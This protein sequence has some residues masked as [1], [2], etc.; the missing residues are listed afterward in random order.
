MLPMQ[1][2]ASGGP[3]SEL[4][5]PS[6]QP[7]G[8]PPP[9]SCSATWTD[10]VVQV[11]AWAA[12]SRAPPSCLASPAAPPPAS[13]RSRRP[14][15]ATANLAPP[16]PARYHQ[17]NCSCSC[18]RRLSEDGNASARFPVPFCP[19]VCAMRC[20]GNHHMSRY[21]SLA[22]MIVFIDGSLPDRVCAWHFRGHH[23]MRLIH[24]LPVPPAC[25]RHDDAG[26]MTLVRCWPPTSPSWCRRLSIAAAR[27]LS[28]MALLLIFR[29]TC[30]H[31]RM[32]G[33]WSCSIV[34]T[35]PHARYA[36]PC[37]AFPEFRS[38][39]HRS[40]LRAQRL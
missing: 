10:S 6:G 11:Q 21:I 33:D 40:N 36:S 27:S 30:S 17:H 13:S 7:A 8:L 29:S 25:R 39:W 2:Q 16:L 5:P 37:S 24:S 26:I 31:H 19:H 38:H 22:I 20:D 1:L 14:R 28:N 23:N 9:A 12:L 15:K 34:L 3:G 32:C 35:A 18:T 4:A